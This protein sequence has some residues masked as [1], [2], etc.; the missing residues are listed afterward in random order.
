[1]ITGFI[2]QKFKELAGTG[3]G[4]SIR[5]KIL[6]ILFYRGYL[7]EPIVEIWQFHSSFFL[8][9]GDLGQLFHKKPFTYVEIVFSRWE[10]MQNS[11]LEK[12]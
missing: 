8:K 1:L 5:V 2:C 4:G 11:T 12:Q 3:I 9:Y 7:L 6:S 10:N